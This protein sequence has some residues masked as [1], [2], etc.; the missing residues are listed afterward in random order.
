MFGSTC[1][2]PRGIPVPAIMSFVQSILTNIWSGN[3]L[4]FTRQSRSLAFAIETEL[5]SREGTF[6]STFESGFYQC[7]RRVVNKL[8]H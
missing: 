7:R 8:F 2:N 5:V 3:A 6:E 4:K 1:L